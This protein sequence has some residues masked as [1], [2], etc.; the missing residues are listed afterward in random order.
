M[1]VF[2]WLRCFLN[3]LSALDWIN[4]AGFF[5]TPMICIWFFPNLRALMAGVFVTAA[6]WGLSCCRFS[7]RPP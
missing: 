2:D 5:S 1:A 3:G 6:F 4:A 7:G